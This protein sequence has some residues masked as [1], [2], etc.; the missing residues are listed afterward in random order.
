MEPN[1]LLQQRTCKA[2]IRIL[3]SRIRHFIYT[4][5]RDEVGELDTRWGPMLLVEESFSK[6]AL[7]EW[8]GVLALWGNLEDQGTRDIIAKIL[9]ESFQEAATEVLTIFEDSE[10]WEIRK[11]VDNYRKDLKVEDFLDQGEP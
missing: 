2:A 5:K 7:R 8:Q 3:K 4:T 10:I 11:L 9:D 6:P 1:E